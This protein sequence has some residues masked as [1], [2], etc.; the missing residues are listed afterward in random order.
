MVVQWGGKVKVSTWLLNGG[1]GQGQYTAS[2]KG[3]TVSCSVYVYSRKKYL[4][5]VFV[6]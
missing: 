6:Y 5:S 4:F 2:V 1:Q 3:E